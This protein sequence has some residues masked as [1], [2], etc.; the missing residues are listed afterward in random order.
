[1]IFRALP[2]VGAHAV[3]PEFKDDERG[4]FARSISVDEFAVNG[5]EG[6]FVEH[7]F[8]FN[9]REGTLRG[10]HY[11]RQPHAEGK[12]VRCTRGSVFDVIVDVRLG[13]A[14][15]GRWHGERL[16]P[17]NRVAVYAPPGVAHGYITLEASSEVLYAMTTRYMAEAAAGFRFD[18]E[19]VGIKWPLGPT[20]MSARDRALRPF[21]G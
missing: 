3:T 17:E 20:V 14:T 16:D 8:A 15:Y 5:C 11:A 9:T 6:V 10:M 7:S 18:D 1:V 4:T 19:R 12:L 13:S 2:I 21:P